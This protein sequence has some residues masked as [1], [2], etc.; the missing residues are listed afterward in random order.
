MCHHIEK[1]NVIISLETNDKCRNDR[2]LTSQKGGGTKLD[3]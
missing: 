2:N 1:N 3:Y